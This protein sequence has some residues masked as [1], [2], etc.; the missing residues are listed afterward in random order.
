A[1]SPSVTYLF[2][3]SHQALDGAHIAFGSRRFDTFVAAELQELE[4]T[5]PEIRPRSGP[6]VTKDEFL[7]ALRKNSVFYYAGHS[8]FDMHNALQSSILLDG[9]KPGPNAISAVDIMQQRIRKNALIILS[10][11][12]TSLGNSRDGAGIGGLTSAFLLGGAGAVVGSL[13]PVESSSTMQ[14]MSQTF[15]SLIRQRQSPADSL[16]A[17]QISVMHNPATRHPYYWSGFIV[18]GNGSAVAR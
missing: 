9:D 17:A 11:C 18:T 8:A 12:Q 6:D 16:R 10:S 14:L 1:E 7:N 2:S 5:D 4:K 3:G 13:W 15:A